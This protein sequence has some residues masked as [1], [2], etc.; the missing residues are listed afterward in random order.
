M[1]SP[2]TPDSVNAVDERLHVLVALLLA[3]SEKYHD[4]LEEKPL[5]TL[6]EEHSGRVQ[7]GLPVHLLVLILVDGSVLVDC[8]FRLLDLRH[9]DRKD[10]IAT[11][12]SMQVV[13]FREIEADSR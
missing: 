10:I 6:I 11:I 3:F 9:L 5:N 13:A 8:V 12:F 1:S 4:F 7:V 2:L